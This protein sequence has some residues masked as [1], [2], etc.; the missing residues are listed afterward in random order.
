[1]L[2]SNRSKKSARRSI[3][4]HC[5]TGHTRRLSL[6]ALED[7]RLL[8]TLTV[9]SLSDDTLANLAGD[10]E[11]SLREAVEAANLDISVDGSRAGRGADTIEFAPNLAGGTITLAGTELT[12]SDDLTIA[13]LGADQLTVRGQGDDYYAG[14]VFWVD[15]STSVEILDLTISHGRAVGEAGGGIHNEGTLRVANSVLLNNWAYYGGAISNGGSLTIENC[16]ISNSLVLEGSAIWNS[17]VLAI[18]DSSFMDNESYNNGGAIWNDG[19]LEIAGS[20]FLGNSAGR[21]GGTIWNAGEVSILDSA[22]SENSATSKGGGI[23]NAGELEVTTSDFSN[24]SSSIGGA[25]DSWTHA[26]ITDSTFSNNNAS[27]KGGGIA[28]GRSLMEITRTT[29]SENTANNVGGGIW[30]MG[31]TLD[32]KEST[33][34]NNSTIVRTTDG[35]GG[36]IGNTSGGRVTV[37]HSVFT[38]NEAGTGGAIDHFTYDWGALDVINSTLT[39]NSSAYSG[40]AI[41]SN[42]PATITGSTISGNTA[43]SFGGGVHTRNQTLVITVSTISNNSAR[44][45][46]GLDVW[47]GTV[48]VSSSTIAANTSIEEGGGIENYEGI[49]KMTNSTIF[50]NST[51][52][53]GGGIWNFGTVETTN[54]T[55]VLNRADAD[56]NGSGNAGGI[57]NDSSVVLLNNTLLAGNAL[58]APGS[59]GPNDIGGSDVDL[60]GSHNLI[61]HAAT[62]GGLS[63]GVNDNIVGDGGSGTIDIATVVDT[64]LAHNSGPTLTHALVAGSPALNAGDNSKAVDVDGAPLVYDQRGVDEEGTGF[65]RIVDG[66]V[67]IGAFEV[68]PPILPVQIAV[69]PGSDTNPI[70]LAGNGLIAVA[71]LT[72]A[73]FDAATVDAST[74]R[75]AEADAVHSALEDVDGDGDLDLVLHFRVQDTNLADVYAQLLAEETDGDGFRQSAVVSLSGETMDGE[76]ILGTDEVNLFFSGRALWELLDSL[77]LAGIL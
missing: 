55:I 33:F 63:N 35:N 68:Q 73:D 48:E 52:G 62:A 75:F 49:L 41:W 61:G 3:S 77:A 6:E 74:V 24:N 67:D 4:H 28:N 34:T 71:V 20:T 1:M 16:S 40:G 51:D 14:R 27:S 43:G 18:S 17:G 32:V 19:L 9:T 22:F 26:S 72:T 29:F 54:V 21:S 58:G 37:S 45:G 15:P 69:K 76:E 7:K 11:L 13:G 36:A 46:G 5:S 47:K 42:S 57:Y 31:G 30:N 50:G 65:D 64:N 39:G 70:N 59:D 2:F 12:I 53:V 25:I 44:F 8:T 38:G 60:S 56:G 10:G 23:S 66:T